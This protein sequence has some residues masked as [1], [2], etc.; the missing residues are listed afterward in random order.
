MNRKALVLGL[1]TLVVLFSAGSRL[2]A[3]DTDLYTD[4]DMNVPPNVLIIFDTSGSMDEEVPD[5]VYNPAYD[6]STE[7]R[8]SGTSL[9]NNDR[10]YRYSSGWGA[11]WTEFSTTVAALNCTTAQDMLNSYGR[12]EGNIYGSPSYGCSTDDI[13]F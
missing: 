13:D 5:R 6:Y 4:R 9:Y 2:H 3:M 10:V 1:G 11:S 8:R 12:W 7:P